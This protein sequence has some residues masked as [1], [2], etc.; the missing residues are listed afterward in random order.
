M[1]LEDV[2]TALA[3]HWDDVLARL[4]PAARTELVELLERVGAGG[5]AGA[6]AAPELMPLLT[7][8]L[9]ADHAVL[10]GRGRPGRPIRSVRP[11]L[12]PTR[13]ACGS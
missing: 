12:C 7:R 3:D 4:K 1:P 11:G 8:L 10:L 2:L 6:A 13:C 5:R 9:P